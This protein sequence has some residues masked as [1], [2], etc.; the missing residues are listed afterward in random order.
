MKS[1]KWYIIYIT[2]KVK[3]TYRIKDANGLSGFFMITKMKNIT[4]TE[5]AV[6]LIKRHYKD[7]YTRGCLQINLKYP[8]LTVSKRLELIDEYYFYDENTIRILSINKFSS[9]KKEESLLQDRLL[10]KLK[11][12]AKNNKTDIKTT[13]KATHSCIENLKLRGDNLSIYAAKVIEELL[14]NKN[15]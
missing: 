14:K 1:D 13:I 7:H 10:Y 2:M 11:I 6:N 9:E 5:E 12:L 4:D 8:T 15:K 3:I